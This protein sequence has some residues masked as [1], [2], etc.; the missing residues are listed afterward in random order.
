[1]TDINTPTYI[2]VT[3]STL[4]TLFLTDTIQMVKLSLRTKTDIDQSI[5]NTVNLHNASSSK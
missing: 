4:I 2:D 5:N 1:M 3:D